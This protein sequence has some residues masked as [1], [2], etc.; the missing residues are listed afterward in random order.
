MSLK[1]IQTQSKLL[2]ATKTVGSVYAGDFFGNILE[3]NEPFSAY[4]VVYKLEGNPVSA[5]CS[6]SILNEHSNVSIKENSNNGNSSSNFTS[7]NTANTNTNAGQTFL[8]AGTWKG[9][10]YRLKLIKNK[11]IEEIKIELLKD[12]IIKCAQYFD[13]FVFAGT[14]NCI[15]QICPFN[16]NIIYNFSVN[17]KPLSMNIFKNKLFVG[18]NTGS[19]LYIEPENEVCRFFDMYN[20]LN[21]FQ[22]EEI[23]KSS[24]IDINTFDIV[25]SNSNKSNHNVNNTASNLSTSNNNN[26]NSNI[27]LDSNNRIPNSSS[28]LNNTPSSIDIT[29][30]ENKKFYK[31]KSYDY[32]HENAIL[33]MTTLKDHL[34]TASSDKSIKHGNNIIFHNEEKWIR[35]ID[36]NFFAADKSLY[37]FKDFPKNRKV[38]LLYSH[39]DYIS[40]VLYVSNTQCIT[41]GL[42]GVIKVY[43]EGEIEL[44]E[45]EQQVLDSLINQ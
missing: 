36:K 27:S 34:L 19:I 4:S 32:S 12:Q 10:L 35:S 11:V 22:G 23:I 39:E 24:L 15:Y 44:N 33:S 17:S 40:V 14:A 2:S 26:K 43:K 1:K 20:S 8:Y 18:M 3:L 21:G 31:L 16:M 5:L 6:L 28:I 7:S 38:A 25:Y 41:F 45:Y 37:T 9:L 29:T 13:G 30:Q 42:D